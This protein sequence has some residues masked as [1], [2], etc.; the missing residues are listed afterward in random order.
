MSNKSLKVIF[1]HAGRFDVQVF[2]DK[3]PC[4]RAKAQGINTDEPVL[5]EELKKLESSILSL[6]LI[7]TQRSFCR[8]IVIEA[9]KIG[10]ALGGN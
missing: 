6:G 9:F 1:P 7:P 10:K 5:P 2:D 4:L 8:Y 3:P